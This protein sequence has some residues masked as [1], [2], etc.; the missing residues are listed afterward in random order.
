MASEDVPTWA[1]VAIGVVLFA[2]TIGT[3]VGGVAWAI[4]KDSAT[5]SYTVE[6]LLKTDERHDKL[7]SKNADNITV[8]KEKQHLEELARTKLEGKIDRSLD[9]QKATTTQLIEIKKEFKDLSDYLMQF[10][11]DKKKEAK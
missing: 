1:K 3:T 2:I 11:Y 6:S 7:I 10:N 4:S 8:M 9:A 5:H